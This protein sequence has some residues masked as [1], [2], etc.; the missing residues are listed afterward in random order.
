MREIEEIEVGKEEGGTR[1]GYIT[2]SWTSYVNPQKSLT[3]IHLRHRDPSLENARITSLLNMLL[4]DYID[5][6]NDDNNDRFCIPQIWY[7]ESNW[8]LKASKSDLFGNLAVYGGK[9]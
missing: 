8:A 6:I 5:D 7:I 3:Q 1:R 4:L 9:K 2:Q